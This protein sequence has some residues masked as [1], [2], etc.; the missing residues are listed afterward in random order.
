MAKNNNKCPLEHI[1]K[2]KNISKDKENN[3]IVCNC[4]NYFIDF[5]KFKKIKK[6]RKP[7][8]SP[9][10]LFIYREK[11]EIWFIEFKSSNEENIRKKQIQIKRKILEGLIIF[12]EILKNY[13]DFKKYYF[14]VYN[15]HSSFNEEVIDNIV[16]KPI[17]FSLE[18]LKGKFLEDVITGNCETFIK[19]FKEKFKIELN[20]KT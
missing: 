15:K 13:F 14:I 10:M 17:E 6:Y 11:K 16:N 9:D 12:Y 4:E 1:R 19:F 18:E 7:P 2:L 3:I 8:S 20:C 5:D